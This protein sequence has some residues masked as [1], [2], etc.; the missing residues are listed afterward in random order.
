MD[1]QQRTVWQ[2]EHVVD[3]REAA[4]ALRTYFEHRDVR[5]FLTRAAGQRRLPAACEIGAGYGRDDRPD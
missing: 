1:M 5:D 4:F 3:V 2:Q